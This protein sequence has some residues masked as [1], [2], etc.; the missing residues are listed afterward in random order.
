M[1]LKFYH[2]ENDTI[3]RAGINAKLEIA[4]QQLSVNGQPFAFRMLCI[5]PS[6][7]KPGR[8]EEGLLQTLNVDNAQ[9]PIAHLA[10]HASTE[11]YAIFLFSHSSGGFVDNVMKVKY[12]LFI[13]DIRRRSL[14]CSTL[15]APLTFTNPVASIKTSPQP[16]VE[17]CFTVPNMFKKGYA[18]QRI[19]LSPKPEVSTKLVSKEKLNGNCVIE[20]MVVDN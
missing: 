1:Q 20:C 17:I 12:T 6:R 9:N 18:M 15:V 10:A 14:E 2:R 3:I 7:I 4:F 13:A 11:E 8:H 19:C 5:D 16:A